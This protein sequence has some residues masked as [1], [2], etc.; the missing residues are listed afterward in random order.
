[1][2]SDLPRR[3]KKQNNNITTQKVCQQA[4]PRFPTFLHSDD[5]RVSFIW[6]ESAVT[7]DQVGQVLGHGQR[8]RRHRQGLHKHTTMLILCIRRCPFALF[9]SQDWKSLISGGTL[10]IGNMGNFKYCHATLC[11]THTHKL[12]LRTTTTNINFNKT[13]DEMFKNQYTLDTFR[14]KEKPMDHVCPF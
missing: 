12:C 14:K 13:F 4:R 7:V 6:D 5:E 1:M 9:M 2:C 3:K 10:N 11:K 8:R